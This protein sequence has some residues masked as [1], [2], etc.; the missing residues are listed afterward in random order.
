MSGSYRLQVRKRGGGGGATIDQ[1]GG[2]TAEPGRPAE[3]GTVSMGGDGG[4]YE[5]RLSVD[6]GG[7]VTVCTERIGGSL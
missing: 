6:V 4:V 7:R 2:F 1:S 3:L 5:A